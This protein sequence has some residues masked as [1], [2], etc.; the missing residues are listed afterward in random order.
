[1]KQGDKIEIEDLLAFQFE[2]AICMR[3]FSFD[4][5]VIIITLLLA[6]I[7]CSL[8]ANGVLSIFPIL[9]HSLLLKNF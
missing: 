5:T 2:L 8:S 3:P 4:A 1:M 6:A 9:S 7:Y